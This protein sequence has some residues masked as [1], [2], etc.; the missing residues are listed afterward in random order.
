MLFR[1]VV[2]AVM[3]PA[4]VIL[5]LWILVTRGIVADG[6][7]WAFIAYLFACPILFVL[8]AIESGIVMA[9][10]S[11]R[12]ARAVSWWDAVVLTALWLALVAS[13]IFA[14]PLIAVAVVVLVVAAFWLAVWEVVTETR[15][16]VNSFMTSLDATAQGTTSR[17]TPTDADVIIITPNS[18]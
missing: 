1:R 18:K 11:V 5:P 16:R 13:G 14:L 3:F 12:D 6:I 8:M 15:T 17:V 2:F 10:K 7:G 4:A 9:R